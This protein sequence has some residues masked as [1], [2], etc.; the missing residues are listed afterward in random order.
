MKQINNYIF[1]RLHINK[2]TGKQVYK[3]H[4]KSRDEMMLI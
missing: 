4:T 3:Y 2:N 1:E